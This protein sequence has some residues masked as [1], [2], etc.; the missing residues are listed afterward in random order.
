MLELFDTF[1]DTTSLVISQI[2]AIIVAG[3]QW[4]FTVPENK[5]WE[6]GQPVEVVAIS[7][8]RNW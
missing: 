8:K 4:I 7:S 6:S 3:S 1:F 2:F 5:H